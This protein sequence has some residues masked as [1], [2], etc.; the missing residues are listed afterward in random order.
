MVRSVAAKLAERGISIDILINNAGI[1][2]LFPLVEDDTSRLRRVMDVNAFGP[3]LVVNAF[4]GDILANRGRVVMISSE[5]VKFPS[6]FQPYQVA[7]IALEA[8]S[9]TIRQELA[10]KGASIIVVRPG[11]IKTRMH[12]DLGN[13]TNPISNS[14]YDAEFKKF[15]PETTRHTGRVTGPE[16]VA[17]KIYRAATSSR[18]RFVYSINNN[19]WLTLMSWIPHLLIQKF[20]ESR[21]K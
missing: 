10:L 3:A 4:L 2:D 16:I 19:P 12:T 18:P 6:L 11:A 14:R 8:Y 5:S 20:I 7:K 15:V 1:F 9:R 13:R 17:E 21:L